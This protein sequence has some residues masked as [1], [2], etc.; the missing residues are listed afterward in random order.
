MEGR[1]AVNLM[2]EGDRSNYLA[3]SGFCKRQLFLS[4]FLYQ[5]GSLSIEGLVWQGS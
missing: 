1:A 4:P 2:S 3:I 5:P